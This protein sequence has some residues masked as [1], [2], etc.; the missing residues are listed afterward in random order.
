MR[1]A[2]D[3]DRGK[4]TENLTMAPMYQYSNGQ[5]SLYFHSRQLFAITGC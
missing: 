2:K 4:R 5:F 1:Y 3:M